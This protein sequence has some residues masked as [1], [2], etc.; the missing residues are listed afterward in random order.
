[1]APV[2]TQAVGGLDRVGSVPLRA[3]RD[4]AA[5]WMARNTTM[6][7][8]CGVFLTCKFICR[9]YPGFAY[10]RRAYGAY[11]PLGDL[12][13]PV[14]RS[15]PGRLS[16]QSTRDVLR[17][18]A[19]Q[20][21]LTVPGMPLSRTPS[22]PRM[23]GRHRRSR[24]AGA[25]AAVAARLALCAL[26]ALL[27]ATAPVAAATDHIIERA[28]FEDVSGTMGI[29][30]VVG[31]RF[32]TVGPLLTRGYSRS[33]HWMR[34]T[35]RPADDGGDLVLRIRPTFLDSVTL[36]EPLA[37]GAGGWRRDTTGD[38]TPHAERSF[39]G[40]ALGFRIQP[41]ADQRTVYLR[42]ETTSSS[43]LNVSALG[44]DAADIAEWRL[45][46]AHAAF[47]GMMGLVL[48]WAV[49]NLLQ[50]PEPVMGW[51]VVAQAAYIGYAMALT[52][53]LAPLLPGPL[54]GHADWLT[55]FLV[56]LTP[57]L[58]MMLH[59][60]IWLPLEPPALIVRLAHGLIFASAAIILLFLSGQATTLAMQ[61]NAV[62]VLSAA[63][64]LLM[65]AFSNLRPSPY[66]RVMLRSV[67]GFQAMSLVV[68]MLPLL[69][70]FDAVEW[71]LHAPLTHGLI[72]TALMFGL[73]QQRGRRLLEEARRAQRSLG[74]LRGALDR[75]QRRRQAQDRFMA[76]LTHEIRTPL[77]VIGLNIGDRHA[78]GERLDAIRQ[79]LADANAIVENCMIADRL[80]HDQAIA[81]ADI[82]AVD[83][84]IAESI[85]RLRATDRVRLRIG[86]VGAITS[87]RRLVE[88]SVANLLDNALKHSAPHRPVT[89]RLD[90][91]TDGGADGVAIAFENAPGRA[92]FPDPDKVF[93]KY[94][95]ASGAHATAG[96]G[97]GLYIVQGIAGL[98]GGSVR[99]EVAGDKVRFVLWLPKHGPMADPA[100]PAERGG[101]RGAQGWAT[102]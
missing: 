25:A 62:L 33:V 26:L 97:L 42:L 37:G 17:L 41:S 102:A 96:S 24:G 95:R 9:K 94:Y 3:A 15:A 39:S 58:A 35:V 83:G 69:G 74:D 79:A 19:R 85:G 89:V 14:F 8:Y 29:D 49:G 71:S 92:G 2:D 93:D 72:Y 7:A 4:V 16:A 32:E 51:F 31:Q 22:T 73:L 88:I 12:A 10:G 43:V 68:S 75:E 70:V 44:A 84:L 61:V 81:G 76:M 5:H 46:F 87:D 21:V 100:R 53:H 40:I 47:F 18:R 50:R 66:G 36:Y 34:L 86:A 64:F 6:E 59:R 20:R 99:Y 67:Y 80:D 101:G 23:T 78:D 77:S 91:R 13:R 52:G 65:L 30:D 98:L 82:V 28:V 56:C 1:M 27:G 60:A 55:S 38:R 11:E 54:S 57:L 45:G 48:V 90:R 63:P